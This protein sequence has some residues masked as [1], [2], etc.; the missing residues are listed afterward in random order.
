M[1]L[2]GL[3][4]KLCTKELQETLI[5]AKVQ[6][7]LMPVKDEVVFILY[8]PP[9]GNLALKISQDA[10]NCSLY[11]TKI[12]KENPKTPPSFCMFLRKYLLNA[13]ICKIEQL[14]LDRVV[15]INFDAKDELMHPVSLKLVVEIMGKYSNIILLNSED[16]VL[17]SIKRVSIDLSSK[18]QI[19][20]G[21][22]YENPPQVKYNPFTLTQKAVEDI[23]NTKKETKL[24]E[25]IISVFEGISIQTA[26]EIIS[27][28]NINC[29][30]T[31]ELTPKYIERLA[32]TMKEFLDRAISSPKPC[33]QEN[34]DGLPVFFSSMPYSTYPEITCKTFETC[35]EMLDYYYNTRLEFFKLKQLKEGLSKTVAKQLKKVDKL[36]QIYTQ[37]INE[38]RKIEDL[39]AKAQQITANIYRLKKGMDSFI[40]TDFTTGE[41]ITVTLDL[42]Y[43]PQDYAKKIYKKITKI[44]TACK[45]N[46]VKL[47]ESEDER[48]F[49]ER[50]LFFI[51][52]AT[53]TADIAEIKESLTKAGYLAPLP[54]SKHTVEITSMPK[55]FVTKAGY[56]VLVGSNDRQNDILTMKIAQKEDIWFHAQ[57]IPGSHVL[58]VTKGAQLNDIDDDSIIMAASLAAKYSRAKNS[59][60]TPVDYAVRKNVKKPPSSKPGKVIYDNYFTVYVNAN[61]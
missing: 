25:Y 58:L 48:D 12:T 35:N 52:E 29:N 38:E 28:S 5:G 46:K 10:G 16:R 51:D 17:D 60:K 49:L 42:A 4:L 15:V 50:Q 8:A 30:Y 32:F 44:K 41:S 31:L 56:T 9:F 59:G 47:E 39:N 26:Q 7:I 2:D 36:I 40:S 1:T 61:E 54:K 57:K 22:K 53:S 37:S 14:G 55:E 24:F 43:A 23:L 11:I 45:L 19:L 27:L 33:I 20:P 34:Q 18:R 3:T 21:A 6:K 13:K